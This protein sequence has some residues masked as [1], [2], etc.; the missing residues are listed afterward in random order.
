VWAFEQWG[1]AGPQVVVVSDPLLVHEVLARG[2]NLDKAAD[3]YNGIDLVRT[4]PRGAA[5][6]PRPLRA[7]RNE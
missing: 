3:A 2:S 1:E 7:G 4:A 5:L 6:R